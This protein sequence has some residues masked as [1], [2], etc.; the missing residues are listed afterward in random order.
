MNAQNIQLGLRLSEHAMREPV[1]WLIGGCDSAEWLRE[2]MRAGVSL[3]DARLFVLPMSRTDLNPRGALVVVDRGDKHELP[4]ARFEP[5]GCVA[6]MLYL[7]THAVVAPAVTDEQVRRLVPFDVAVFH[8]AIGVVGF[9]HDDALRAVDLIAPPAR[10]DVNWDCATPGTAL[11]G[12]LVSIEPEFTPTIEMIE[13]MGRDD[14]GSEAKEKLP[15]APDE[16]KDTKSRNLFRRM[17]HGMG[18]AVYGVTSKIP[19]SED[20]SPTWI[21]SLE[22]WAQRQMNRASSA[23]ESLRQKEINRLLS[24]LENDPE[25]G[26]RHAIPLSGGAGARGLAPPSNTLGTNPV[27]FSLSGLAGGGAVDPWDISWEKQQQLMQRYRDLA[28]REGRLKRF[29]RAAYIYAS[30]LGDIESAANVLAEGGHHREAAV[31]YRDRLNRPKAAAECLEKGGLY[32]EAIQLY[33]QIDEYECAAAVYEKIEQWDQ[34][35]ACFRKAVEQR[36]AK[37]DRIGAAKLLENK[38]DE[39]DEAIEVLRGGWPNH[40]QARVCLSSMFELMANTDRSDRAMATAKEMSADTSID[41]GRA[42]ELAQVLAD[43]KQSWPKRDEMDTIV[44]LVHTIAARH[45]RHCDTSRSA[46]FMRAIEK[47]APEDRLLASDTHRYVL[48]RKKKSIAKPKA[49]SRRS[50]KA[51]GSLPTVSHSRVFRLP[52]MGDGKWVM[53]SGAIEG[54]YAVH[55]GSGEFTVARSAWNEEWYQTLAWSTILPFELVVDHRMS[56]NPIALSWNTPLE[57]FHFPPTDALPGVEAGTP[58]WLPQST[59]ACAVRYG[60]AWVLHGTVAENGELA[61]SHFSADG[62][63]VDSMDVALSQEVMASLAHEENPPT[64]CLHVHRDAVYLGLGRALMKFVKNGEA[65]EVET[66]FLSQFIEGIVCAAPFARNRFLCRHIKGGTLIW[67]DVGCAESVLVCADEEGMRSCFT[68]NSGMLVVA[69]YSEPKRT[70]LRVFRT[71][72]GKVEHVVTHMYPMS[73]PVAMMPV[74]HGDSFAALL[75][76]GVMPIFEIDVP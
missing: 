63:L 31:L 74:G 6:G 9:E 65:I 67:D 24:M 73:L 38:L 62:N 66:R 18:S 72:N 75:E 5:Y 2:L 52:K 55:S 43:Q 10:R 20:A 76:N 8:P 12:R 16:P 29:R 36:L 61:L 41:V 68:N 17:Q 26:L 15:P 39:T 47:L 42:S 37:S 44:G 46:P 45:L 49:D 7:P 70:E 4:T 25:A 23:I 27:N 35:N 34:A 58:D 64:P 14:I 28:A 51:F 59:L 48:N 69:V 54:F 71:T 21:N 32:A 1:A 13:Q 30:L 22:D 19:G 33:E 57:T 53:A 3:M 56:Q 40:A 60:R 50:S 11:N